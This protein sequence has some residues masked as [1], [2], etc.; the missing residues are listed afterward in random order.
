MD[1]FVKL[2]SRISHWKLTQKH[3]SSRTSAHHINAFNK[4]K[5]GLMKLHMQ[6]DQVIYVYTVSYQT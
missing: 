2:Y 6:F 1:M 4:I 3:K 5:L